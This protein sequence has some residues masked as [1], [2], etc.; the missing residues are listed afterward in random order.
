M[1]SALVLITLLVAGPSSAQTLTAGDLQKMC[2]ATA[3]SQAIACASYIQGYV[4]GRNQSLPRPTVCVPPGTSMGDAVAGYV[5]YVAKNRLEA[6]IEAGLVLGN[7][8]L[9]AFPCR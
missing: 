4:N 6:N 9:S 3:Q 2:A 1:R 7:Y 8:L 5:D